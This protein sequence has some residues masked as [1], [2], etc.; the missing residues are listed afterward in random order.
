MRAGSHPDRG[1]APEMA[2]RDPLRQELGGDP[3]KAAQALISAAQAQ[4]APLHLFLG[5]DAF[6]QARG[7]IQSVQQELARWREMSVSIGFVDE[8]RLAA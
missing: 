2:A 3:V 7:K 6:D 1:D 5:R 8:R 4:Y